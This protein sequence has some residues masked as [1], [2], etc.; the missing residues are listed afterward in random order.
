MSHLLWAYLNQLWQKDLQVSVRYL[1]KE[2]NRCP[3]HS[4][5]GKAEKDEGPVDLAQYSDPGMKGHFL[6][7]HVHHNLLATE[8]KERLLRQIEGPVLHNSVY[9]RQVL[10]LPPGGSTQQ[11]MQKSAA[12]VTPMAFSPEES[13]LIFC[14]ATEGDKV[15]KV[16]KV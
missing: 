1:L 2:V 8:K 4:W 7:A 14:Q 12:F 5:I 16:L 10:R 6:R 15:L 11:Q 9:F 3:P 13:F